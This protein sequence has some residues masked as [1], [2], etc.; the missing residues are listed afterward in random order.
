MRSGSSADGN[1]VAARMPDMVN[2]T[3]GF[4]RSAI[5]VA[6]FFAFAGRPVVVDIDCIIRPHGH[7][8]GGQVL[9][10]V[11]RPADFVI[12]AGSISRRPAAGTGQAMSVRAATVPVVRT[13]RR[14]LDSGRSSGSRCIA[15]GWR[16]MRNGSGCM[17]FGE[18]RIFAANGR[19]SGQ[20]V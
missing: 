5:A 16:R 12:L 20:K 8:D 6:P 11:C 10:F 17:S 19:H 14:G 9:D 15:C 18:V 2:H 1:A 13:V 7:V 3:W 4:L